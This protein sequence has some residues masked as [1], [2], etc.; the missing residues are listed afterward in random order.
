[1]QQLSTSGMRHKFADFME[2]PSSGW[3]LSTVIRRI[4]DSIKVEYHGESG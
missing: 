3:I 4:L 2:D 1:M